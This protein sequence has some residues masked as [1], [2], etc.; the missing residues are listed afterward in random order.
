MAL[1]YE[2][3]TSGEKAAADLQ[4]ILHRFGCDR[5]GTMV[6]HG[7]GIL[8][9]QFSYRG[10]DVMV[11]AS[12]HGYAAALLKEHPHSNRAR[13]S[14][15]AYESKAKET[16]S[17]AVYSIIRDWIKG[18]ITAIETGVLSF[19]GAFLGQLLLPSGRT[20]LE[21]VEKDERF[22]LAAPKVANIKGGT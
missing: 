19:E 18:Q 8:I 14:L 5:F 7:E 12:I 10:R 6:D 9:C 2:N 16:A 20:V 4:K 11:K 21:T 15:K 17:I 13:M 1:P 3:A 22:K